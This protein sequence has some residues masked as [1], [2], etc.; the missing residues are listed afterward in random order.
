MAKEK[1][2]RYLIRESDAPF[3]KI[4]DE[5]VRRGGIMI[6]G[7]KY[8]PQTKDGRDYMWLISPRDNCIYFNVV[9]WINN[10]AA[11]E[12]GYIRLVYDEKTD[13][14]KE[15]IPCWKWTR[16]RDVLPDPDRMLLWALREPQRKNVG[17]NGVT[18][19]LVR[20]GVSGEV[21]ADD[22]QKILEM[23]KQV[24]CEYW[25]CYIQEIKND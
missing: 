16:Y 7:T 24:G 15:M 19:N 4:I 22:V 3:E 14:F 21:L 10:A 6:E 11:D 12:D 17:M 18:Y 13:K 23:E 9:D 25:W 1:F 8:S 5:L 20:Y 2:N